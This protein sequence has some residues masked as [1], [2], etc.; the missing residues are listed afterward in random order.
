MTATML[1]AAGPA[2][3]CAPDCS[4]SCWAD[5]A[6]HGRCFGKA[7]SDL[8]LCAIHRDRLHDMNTP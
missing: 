8:G 6:G 4:L 2:I 5:N 3:T 1:P 7:V